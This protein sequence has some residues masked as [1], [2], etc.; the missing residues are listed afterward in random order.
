MR[1]LWLLIGIVVAVGLF[2]F[3]PGLFNTIVTLVQRLFDW[4]M[5]FARGV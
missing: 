2:L 1:I 5:G 4:I 3:F